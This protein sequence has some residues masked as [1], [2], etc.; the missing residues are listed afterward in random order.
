MNAPL[1]KRFTAKMF[2]CLM[3]VT[4]ITLKKA[5]GQTLNGMSTGNYAGITGLSFNPASI[6]DSRFKFDLNLASGQYFFANNYVD[7]NPL[8]FA[9][10]YLRQEP[11]NGSFEAVKKDLI[12]PR[13]PGPD[14]VVQARMNTELMLP[15]SFMLTTGKKSAIAV[16]LR[17]RFEQTINNLNP[18]TASIFYSE[19]KDPKLHGITMNNNN[20]TQNFMN[21]QEIGFTYGRVIF[22]ANRHFLKGA[23]TGK[24]LGGNAASYIQADSLGVT[25]HDNHTLSLTSPNIQ[26]ARTVRADF[27]LFNKREI[28]NNL[29]SKSF[30]YDIGFVYEF[31]GRIGDFMYKDENLEDLLRRDK[32]K[33]SFRLGVALN[34]LGMLTYNR[35]PLTRDHSA[36]INNWDFSGVR[37][38]NIRE[39]DT[40]YAKKVNYFAGG[41]STFSIALPVSLLINLDIRL[42]GGFYVNAAMQQPMADKFFKSANTN[43]NSGKWFA[44]TPRFEGRWFGIYV[45]LLIRENNIAQIG[46]TVRVGPFFAGSNNLLALVQNPQVPGSDVH[47]GIRLPISFGKPSKLA[48]L[49]DKNATMVSKLSDDFDEKLDSSNARQSSMDARISFLEKMMDSAYRQP[50]VVIV[51]TYIND[52][53]VRNVVS[54]AEPKS[55]K[56]SQQNQTRAATSKSAY[57]AEQEKAM[58]EE[59]R[60]MRERAKQNLKEQGINEPKLKKTSTKPTKNERQAEKRARA[61]DKRNRQFVKSTQQY[62]KAVERELRLMRRQQAI[63][64]TALTTAVAANA[65]VN[66][67]NNEPQVVTVTDTLLV[68]DSTV[69]EDSSFVGPLKPDTIVIRDTIVITPDVDTI[70]IAKAEKNKM[71]PQLTTSSI[72]FASGSANIRSSYAQTLNEVAAWMLL[73]PERQVMLTGITDATGSPELNRK[74]ATQRLAAVRNALVSRGISKERFKTDTQVSTTRTKQPDPNNRRVDISAIE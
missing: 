11:Y 30:G 44:I 19:L 72:L 7:A 51:N 58:K 57:T 27:D 18:Q 40:A 74:L 50:P 54:T 64:G 22:N 28:F 52:S 31:R 37:A 4:S 36:N 13:V 16:T 10:R 46:T 42:F 48:L 59:E 70:A 53:V 68:V 33:Y 15:L 12:S 35:M 32:N 38:N 56:T 34:D 5:D 62:N 71:V 65:V 17:N 73:N 41:D 55:T 69:L 39:W 3:A 66:A 45:P 26:Y 23:I 21:W 47:A 8:L 20:F 24:W 60:Q 25:F 49:V 61:A 29:E 43:L 67:N 14:G 6:V 1:L 2:I 9:R 63:A